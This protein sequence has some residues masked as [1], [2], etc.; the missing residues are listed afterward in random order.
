MT[1]PGILFFETK[2]FSQGWDG[3]VNESGM[4]P[5][6]VYMYHIQFSSKNGTKVNKT[7]NLTLF[8]P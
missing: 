2:N 8:Y 6:G 3:S 1:E 4:A 5:Q 7:G